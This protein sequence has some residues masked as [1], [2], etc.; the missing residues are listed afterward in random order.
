MASGVALLVPAQQS[1]VGANGGRRAHADLHGCGVHEPLVVSRACSRTDSSPRFGAIIVV[2][3]LGLLLLLALITYDGI[4]E[5]GREGWYAL[6]AVLAIAI[7]L[8]ARELSYV[9]V[10]GIWFPFGTGVSRTQYA[11]AVFDVALAVL[12]VRRLRG[13]ARQRLS[14]TTNGDTGRRESFNQNVLNRDGRI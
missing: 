13:Y 8:F 11:Y 6:P 7:G 12:F 2:V 10:R 5:R 4:H 9:H 1:R 14:E 3:R